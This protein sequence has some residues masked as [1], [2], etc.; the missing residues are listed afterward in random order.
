MWSEETE[1]GGENKCMAPVFVMWVMEGRAGVVGQRGASMEF[2]I[3]GS[4]E[5]YA[6]RRPVR[7]RTRCGSSDLRPCFFLFFF[8]LFCPWPVL[9]RCRKKNKKVCSVIFRSNHVGKN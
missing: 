1:V 4:H 8:I 3:L 9:L 2:E 6:I 7:G 5:I